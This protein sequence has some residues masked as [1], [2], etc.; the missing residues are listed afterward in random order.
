MPFDNDINNTR[1]IFAK[2]LRY[3]LEKSGHTQAELCKHLGVSSAAVSMWCTGRKSP[4]MDKIQA[5]CNY[6]H[7]RKSDLIED[8]PNYERALNPQVMEDAREIAYFLSLHPEYRLPFDLLLQVTPDD[9]CLIKSFLERL[10][11]SSPSA[12]EN[13]NKEDG[14]VI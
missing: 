3:Y 13:D 9:L 6:L 5:I 11:S 1:T 14:F 7:I 8:T 2:N 12:S 4:R 10:K